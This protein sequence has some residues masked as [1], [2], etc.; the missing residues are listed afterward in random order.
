MME[1]I[2]KGQGNGPEYLNTT[3]LMKEK[4][5]GGCNTTEENE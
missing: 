4:R 5:V 1:V 2:T 3:K